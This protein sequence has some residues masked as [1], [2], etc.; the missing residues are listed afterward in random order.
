M[1]SRTALTDSD[2]DGMP[3]EWE[4]KNRLDPSANDAAFFK[5]DKMFTNIEVYLNSLVKLDSN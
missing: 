5:L 1:K 2:F 4:R 3:D